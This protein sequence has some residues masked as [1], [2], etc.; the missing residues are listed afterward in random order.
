[1]GF[2]ITT[3]D[4][5]TGELEDRPGALAEKLEALQRA[6]ANLEFV[7][8]RPSGDVMSSAGLLF[9]AP[10]VGQKQERAATEV[11]LEKNVSLH[12]LRLVGPDRPGLAAGIARTL[13]DARIN[14]TS[15]WATSLGD[16]SALY[17][18][19]ESSSDARRAAQILAPVL[20]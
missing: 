2:E 19:L 9:V 1:M 8:L 16:Q 11:G 5:W 6:G 10:L 18:R 17:V 4:V 13:A 7:I 20:T 3:A 12:A 14:I 15:L